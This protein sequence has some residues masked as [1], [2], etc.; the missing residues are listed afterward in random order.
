MQMAQKVFSNRVS[1]THNRKRD[2]GWVTSKG[3]SEYKQAVATAAG[4][5][6]IDLLV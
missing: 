6:L 1:R 5:V 2:T 4:L 3:G